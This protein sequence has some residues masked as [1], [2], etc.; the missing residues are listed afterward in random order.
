MTTIS[1]FPPFY[2]QQPNGTTLAQQLSLWQR[3]I[4]ATCKQRRQF[5][6][7]YSDDIWANDKIKRAA[8]KDFIGAILESIVKDGVAAFT[9]ASKDSV[10]V[11]WRSLAEWSEIVYDYV[12]NTAQLNT[13]LTYYELTQGEYS[14][15]SELHQLPVEILKMAINILTKQSKAAIIKSS[16]GEGVKFF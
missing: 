1:E 14:H 5:K 16:Q 7:S 12:L 9:D 2:T 15:L 6:L 10:W 3:H 4:L 13:P 11:Y 8:S